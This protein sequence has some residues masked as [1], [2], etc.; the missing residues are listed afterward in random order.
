LAK[1][2]EDGEKTD[3]EEMHDVN[4]K[5]AFALQLHTIP[6]INFCNLSENL[7]HNNVD[8]F[9]KK[10]FDEEKFNTISKWLSQVSCVLYQ[11]A[12]V[13]SMTTVY[14]LIR[15]MIKS[16]TRSVEQLIISHLC[17]SISITSFEQ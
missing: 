5:I 9:S 10:R 8:G 13:I 3:D 17:S 12:R 2:G 14:N 6:Y 1:E 7:W 15:F 11:R 4:E 16:T